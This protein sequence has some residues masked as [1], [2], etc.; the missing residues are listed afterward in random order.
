MNV[1][2]PYCHHSFNLTRDYLAYAIEQARE[3]GQKHHAVECI[4]CRKTIKVSIKQMQRFV[5][6]VAQTEETE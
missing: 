2:C 6:A 4:N 1:H 5:P 3:K